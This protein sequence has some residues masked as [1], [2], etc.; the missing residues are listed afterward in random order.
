ML[1]GLFT[2]LGWNLCGSGVRSWTS[3]PR[4]GFISYGNGSSRVSLNYYSWSESWALIIEFSI[5]AFTY[6]D[7][8][9]NSS[10]I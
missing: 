4:F 9:S 10:V 7:S 2:F 8:P 6:I 5:L 1:F 3:P